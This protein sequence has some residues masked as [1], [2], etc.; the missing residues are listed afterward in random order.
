MNELSLNVVGFNVHGL[1]SSY[2]TVED[3]IDNHDADV[4]F[5]C[6]HWLRNAELNTFSRQFHTKSYWSRFKSSMSDETENIGRPYGGLGWVCKRLPGVTYNVIETDSDRIS[7]LQVLHNKVT[8]VN[9]IGVYMPFYRRS[10][11]Q[12]NLYAETL[13]K[14]QALLDRFQ[15]ENFM[16]LGDMNT[17]LPQQKCLS[18]HWYKRHPFTRHSLLMY[19]FLLDNELCVANF[20]FSQKVNYSYWNATCRSYIDHVFMPRHM[21]SSLKECVIMEI[22]DNTSDH[23]PIRLQVLFWV[24]QTGAAK[25]IHNPLESFNTAA[26]PRVD[27]SHN[28]SRSMYLN[29]VKS[30]IKDVKVWKVEDI[31]CIGRSRG[32]CE[33]TL[34]NTSASDALKL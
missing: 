7:V 12:L 32:R 6:E 20:G 34:R 1:N 21:L 3:L 25:G 14:L 19:D 13:H 4:V 30:A 10:V 17:T 31:T 33:G 24:N 22:S 18:G 29:N 15:G 2:H 27:W 8:L 9:V 5:V 28:S 23:L 16:I 11:E 26:F